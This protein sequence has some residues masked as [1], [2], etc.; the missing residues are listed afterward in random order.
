[1]TVKAIRAALATARE[2]NEVTTEEVDRIALEAR[3]GWGMGNDERSTLLSISGSLKDEQKQRMLKHVA[4]MSQRNAW[5]NLEVGQVTSIKGRY[6]DCTLAVPGLGAKVGLFENC[7]SLKGV[8]T[9]N[10]ALKL[11][12]EGKTVTV[13]V[14]KGETAAEVLENVRSQLPE[15]VSAALLSGEAQPFDMAE[16]NGAAPAMTDDSAHLMLYKPEALGLKPG[17]KPM[18][19]VVTGYGAFMGITDNPSAALAQK[20]AERGVTG[21]LVEY[22]RLDVTP[23]AVETFMA[24]MRKSP[25]DVI[26]S[27]GVSWHA[28]V[29]EQ[30]ENKLAAGVDGFDKPMEA[31]PVIA[32]RGEV[33]STD[34]PVKEISYALTHRGASAEIGTSLT[35]RAYQPDRSAYLCNFLGYSLAAEFGLSAKTTAGFVH[36]T[37]ETP[38]DQLGTLLDAVVGYQLTLRRK[39]APRS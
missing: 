29:E 37:R 12:L 34:L 13:Q 5:V 4:A 23:A 24:E 16:Y 31:R 18:R 35:D 17:E 15:G 10:G 26:L 32:G 28:Q 11:S 39:D 21:A 36:V 19:V 38:A 20:L 6:A 3:S 27:M 8:A 22:R 25:P 2:D 1:M 33:L 7:L 30:P 14:K 9:A